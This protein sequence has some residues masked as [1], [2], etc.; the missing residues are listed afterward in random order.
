MARVRRRLAT[1]ALEATMQMRLATA[2][3][4]LVVIA[5]RAEA[6]PIAHPASGLQ[7]E[8]CRLA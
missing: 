4:A 6:A 5:P 2:A 8:R 7:F 1:H 3:L